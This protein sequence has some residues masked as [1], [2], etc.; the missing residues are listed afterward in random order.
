MDDK[1]IDVDNNV[2][3]VEEPPNNVI[4]DKL[5][6]NSLENNVSNEVDV[7]TGEEHKT[8]SSEQPVEINKTNKKGFKLPTFGLKYVKSVPRNVCI[9]GIIIFFVLGLLLGKMFFSKNYCAASTKRVIENKKLV[10]DG[11]NNIT[12]VNNFKYKIPNSYIYDKSDGYLLIYDADNKFKIAIRSIKGSYDDLALSKVSIKE[13]VKEQ[14]YVVNDI[15]EL[16]VSNNNYI[17]LEF[18]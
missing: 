3:N 7:I 18:Y 10:A 1:N 9:I 2:T 17:V 11:K 8:D 12:E 14:G 15:K 16:V 5:E 13:S 4:D 6:D